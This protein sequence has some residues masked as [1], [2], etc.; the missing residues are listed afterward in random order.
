[1]EITAPT[2]GM[3]AQF[4]PDAGRIEPGGEFSWP[5]SISSAGLSF[6]RDISHSEHSIKCESLILDLFIPM[7]LKKKPINL[8]F[9]I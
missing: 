3:L 5:R 6:L 2:R 4:I 8:R 9:R 7:S 1:M